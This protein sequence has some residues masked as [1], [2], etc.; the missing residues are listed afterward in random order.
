MKVSP[1]PPGVPAGAG[2]PNP[3]SWRRHVTRNRLRAFILLSVAVHLVLGMSWGVPAY[4]KQ[5]R[6]EAEQRRQ[7]AVLE[8][9]R[10]ASKSALAKAKA[11]DLARTV[12]DVA[13][14][15]RKAFDNLTGDL[16]QSDKDKTWTAV[17]P[18][19][20]PAE[21]QLA[22]ALD[23]RSMTDQDLRNLQANVDRE[24]VESVNDSLTVDAGREEAEA[25]LAG[26]E[27]RVVPELVAHY[28]SELVPKVAEP[29]RAAADV[30]VKAQGADASAA[31]GGTD[32]GRHD[33]IEALKRLSDETDAAGA[34]ADQAQSL[35]TRNPPALDEEVKQHCEA[36]G[37]HLSAAGAAAESAAAG[38][39]KLIE[40][41]KPVTGGADIT[42]RLGAASDSLAQA[43]QTL[44]AAG[45]ALSA[46]DRAGAARQITALLLALRKLNTEWASASE[47]A[48]QAA[49]RAEQAAR[50]ALTLV[51]DNPI[52]QQVQGHLTG[53]FRDKASQRLTDVLTDALRARL[54]AAGVKPDDALVASTA[55]RLKDLLETK[56][57]DAGGYGASTSEALREAAGSSRRAT[58]AGAEPLARKF[59]QA[60]EPVIATGA[61]EVVTDSAIDSHLAELVSKPEKDA[62]LNDVRD[63]VAMLAARASDGRSNTLDSVSLTDLRASAMARSTD[64]ERA[65]AADNAAAPTTEAAPPEGP[66]LIDDIKKEI[67]ASLHGELQ[68]LLDGKLAADKA[69]K[70]WDHVAAASDADVNHLSKDLIDPK[71]SDSELES[72][73][74]DF[75]GKFLNSVREGLDKTAS[76]DVARE[77]VR[78][79]QGKAGDAVA[80]VYKN[81]MKENVGK[82]L[83]H[84]WREAADADAAKAAQEAR[85][86][87][88][89]LDSAE[90]VAEKAAQVLDQVKTQTARAARENKGD[91]AAVHAAVE[92]A[93][94]KVQEVHT[95]IAGSKDDVE[96]AQK[97]VPEEAA[98]IKGHLAE[99]GKSFD[100]VAGSLTDADKKGEEGDAGAFTKAVA[101]ARKEVEKFKGTVSSGKADLDRQAAE[102]RAQFIKAAQQAADDS[103]D[104]KPGVKTRVE[105]K[106]N[107]AFRAEALPRL[108]DQVMKDF[109]Q[110]LEQAGVA[111][112]EKD[113][114]ELHRAVSAALDQKVTGDSQIG[115]A[116]L[117]DVQG[118]KLFDGAKSAKGE[119]T[120]Q[121]SERANEIAD[122]ITT[123]GVTATVEGDAAAGAARNAVKN[124]PG[125]DAGVSELKDKVARMQG[126]IRGGRGGVLADAGDGPD[127][128]GDTAGLGNMRR[129]WQGL[130]AGLNGEGDGSGG[131]GKTA[132]AP[133]AGATAGGGATGASSAGAGPARG[134]GVG[135]GGGWLGEFGSLLGGRVPVNKKLHDELVA[136][137]KDRAAQQ[138]ET[139]DRRGADGSAGH[140][141]EPES[142]RPASIL[143]PATQ[144]AQ[145]A[146]NDKAYV[147]TFKSLQFA[148]VPYLNKPIAIGDNFQAWND[149]PALHLRP[150]RAWVGNRAGLNILDD[151]PIKMA[152]DGH[153]LYFMLDMTD[154]QGKPSA[155]AHQDNFW[156]CDCLEVFVD[157]MNTK[158]LQRGTGAGQQFW[159]WP[160]G[161]VED[162][163]APGGESFFSRQKGF[164]FVGLKQDELPRFARRTAGGYQMQCRIPIER[165]RDADLAPGKILGCNITVETGYRMH[166][167]WSASKVVGTSYHPD[168]WGDIL[169]GGSDGKVDFPDK[170]VAEVGP[171]APVKLL[172]AFVLG[173]P[174]RIRVTDHDMNLNEKVKDKVS[175]TVRNPRGEQEVAILE[176]TG[177]DT[178]VFE[179]SVRTALSLG[180]KVPGV[181]SA[182]E[183]EPLTVTYVDQARA[184][185]ARNVEIVSRITAGPSVMVGGK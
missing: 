70:V 185:G 158:E 6:L 63:R 165:V 65:A 44:T 89:A 4:V 53:A 180:E 98:E 133:G 80:G 11:A 40:R 162:A 103:A 166:Y 112:D 156:E 50:G 52:P 145:T 26:V 49:P 150:E 81:A 5:K 110:K 143:T 95:A 125:P 22:Q 111:A 108:A 124:V 101:D 120:T 57:P 25:F 28:K 107:G 72:R 176:E 148:V 154:P 123:A 121:Q 60:A 61:V 147:P 54:T 66:P 128:K 15:T 153:G 157:T 104:G 142:D 12:Q 1:H 30:F 164:N 116:A 75:S 151:L 59:T 87:R 79:L 91:P 55:K 109:R 127:T 137:L 73:R 177:R 106:F 131:K 94:G 115:E 71:V 20:Q 135:V 23:D 114:Q 3:P 36:A 170:L 14:K 2:L 102:A 37:A 42:R 38:L 29:V 43:R 39:S 68:K 105:K 45:A 146:V 161:S 167:Y 173:E 96:K 41:A 13:E 113:D 58:V 62:A 31:L 9:Q 7:E 175:V 19:L 140:T 16:A 182:Y 56:V 51:Q 172:K 169:L 184:N 134:P 155:K 160:F 84:E 86:V 46:N 64:T 27:S 183:G 174:L 88:D 132:G 118:K 126:Q 149:I 76:A 47:A 74:V 10:Q 152:W 171:D 32:A 99:V 90:S 141:D 117:S 139:W 34:D 69:A 93:R 48:D 82:A 163:A 179:G 85:G 119:P 178:G 181:V 77:L 136:A 92:S 159:Y 17:E 144:P 100:A 138:G 97:D 122:K 67:L 130:L 129:K 18:K 33:V 168:T 83:G 8:Q 24:L 78:Q 35:S 21:Q